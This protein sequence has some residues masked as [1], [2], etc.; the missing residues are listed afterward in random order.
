MARAGSRGPRRGMEQR[1]ADELM[2]LCTSLGLGSNVGE[3]DKGLL[4]CILISPGSH[5]HFTPVGLGTG[6]VHL[7][8]V[9]LV[10]RRGRL[11]QMWLSYHSSL[12]PLRGCDVD[13]STGNIWYPPCWVATLGLKHTSRSQWSFLEG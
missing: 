13:S 6:L 2:S 8:V 9:A 5:R 12:A 1:W 4:A 3:H 7:G 11:W 10:L